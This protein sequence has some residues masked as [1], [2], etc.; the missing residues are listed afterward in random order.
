M[1]KLRGAEQVDLQGVGGVG[2]ILVAGAEGFF[3]VKIIVPNGPAALNGMVRVGDKLVSVSGEEVH[4]AVGERIREIALGV[5]DSVVRLGL[6]RLDRITSRSFVYEINVQRLMGPSA[7]EE[8]IDRTPQKTTQSRAP[9]PQPLGTP[10][11]TVQTL[12]LKP[13][14]LGTIPCTLKRNPHNLNP[15]PYT[16]YHKPY[17]NVHAS[18]RLIVGRISSG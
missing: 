5:P 6:E 13:R 17:R 18:A 12:I 10:C 9:H 16:L 1:A 11:S 4:G 2:L 8:M 3:L 15:K 14:T 7:S